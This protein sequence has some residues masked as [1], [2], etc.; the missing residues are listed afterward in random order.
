MIRRPWLQM[1]RASFVSR[2]PA[3]PI[4]VY[5]SRWMGIVSG[6][7]RPNTNNIFLCALHVGH[8]SFRIFISMPQMLPAAANL[9][10]SPSIFT[11]FSVILNNPHFCHNYLRQSNTP[12][13]HNKSLPLLLVCWFAPSLLA[14]P[15]LS[16]SA[17]YLG[18][19]SPAHS[20]SH[21]RLQAE[22]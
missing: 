2:E 11:F 21:Y 16:V 20:E 8:A 17:L 22:L 15:S 5:K 13:N 7:S 3:E 10:R 6:C 18:E 19:S 9:P 12:K 1:H 4:C 14:A